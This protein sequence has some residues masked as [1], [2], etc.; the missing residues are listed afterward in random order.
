M[1]LVAITHLATSADEEASA[2]AAELGGTAYEQRLRLA[3]GCPAIVLQTPD[4]DRAAEVL[5]RL[6]SRGHGAEACDD[7]AIVPLDSMVALRD[8]RFASDAIECVGTHGEPTDRVR[9][10]DLLALVRLSDRRSEVTTTVE[11]Q[12]SFSAARAIASGGL[13]V[14][15]TTERASTT[16][17]DS[18]EQVLAL[19]RRAGRPLAL[20]ETSAHY[21]ALGAERGPTTIVNFARAVD[22]IRALAPMA[23]YDD[24]LLQRKLRDGDGGIE[25]VAHLVAMTIARR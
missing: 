10:D 14:T 19:Y 24:R 18:K 23:P 4:R 9:Y 3:A 12:R 6:R 5:T 21:D 8:F 17:S 20:R 16:R 2:L 11:K 25:V 13:V 1:F 15:K 22:R 7:A